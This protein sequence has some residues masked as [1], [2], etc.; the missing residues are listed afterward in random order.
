[1]NIT[2][3]VKAYFEKTASEFDAL[4][5]TRRGKIFHAINR[6]LRSDIYDR[7]ELTFS[8]CQD[9]EGCS[10]LDV[11]CGSGRYA[12]E[13]A[14]RGARKVVGVDFA[15]SMI[16]L[17]VSLSIEAGMTEQ[18]EF[19]CDDFLQVDFRERFDYSLAMGV[20]DYIK[21]PESFLNKIGMITT[22]KFLASFPKNTFPR[23]TQRRIRYK[24]KGCPVYFYKREDVEG[25]LTSVGM[26]SFKIVELQGDYFVVISI[27]E[28][29]R[30]Q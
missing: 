18:C 26:T 12:I 13:F 2:E 28:N 19:V 8:E 7:F 27:A 1:M 15:P 3:S 10:V 16:D 25:V 9:I 17:A 14:R 6:L 22:R 24:L 21:Q 11:G 20:F 5:T 29:A 4:Y 30:L 23:S